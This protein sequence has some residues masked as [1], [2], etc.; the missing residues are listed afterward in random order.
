MR[1]LYL[2][3]SVPLVLSCSAVLAQ[4]TLWFGKQDLPRLQKVIA[5]EPEATVWRGIL[6]QAE[7]Y[8]TTGGG[9][10]ADPSTVDQ[11]PGSTW[12]VQVV[13][14]YFGRRLTN[15]MEA[16]G[17]AYQLT[18][19]A[20][21]ARQGVLVLEAAA[22]KLPVTEP[23]IAQGFAGARGDIVR[24]LAVGYDW[25]GEA[26]TP[27]QKR[28]WAETSAGY[29]RSILGEAAAGKTWWR[30]HHNFMGVAVG[31]AGLLSLQLEP[32]FPGEAPKWREQ[33]VGLVRTWLEKGFDEQG[34]YV[35]GTS[36][37]SYGLSQRDTLRGCPWQGGRAGPVPERASTARAA[38]LRD[39][40]AAG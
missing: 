37:A 8:C 29:V 40:P 38:L 19:D 34:A 12:R 27:E 5:S 10:Y 31:A 1:L 17:L 36:Y 18:G 39:V 26:M 33:C 14:H 11:R 16:L 7:E 35:E 25:L 6:R 21:F 15:W 23:D 22:R 32:F 20:R 3:A 28:A 30:P 24:G 13:G 9:Q 4:P 2:A